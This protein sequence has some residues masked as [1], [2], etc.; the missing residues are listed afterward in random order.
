MA[1]TP[2]TVFIDYVHYTPGGNRFVASLIYKQL[3]ERLAA[4][5]VK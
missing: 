5:P 1:I 3:S 4:R 2:E